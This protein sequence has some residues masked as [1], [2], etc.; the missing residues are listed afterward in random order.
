MKVVNWPAFSR[1]AV[2]LV[3]P[4]GPGEAG[5]AWA[6]VVVQWREKMMEKRRNGKY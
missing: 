2:M 5:W 3:G 4:D 1:I 6:G